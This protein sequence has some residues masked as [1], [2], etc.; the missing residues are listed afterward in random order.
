M[1]I[2][3]AALY[4]I[5]RYGFPYSLDNYLKAVAEMGSAGFEYCELEINVDNDL[6]EYFDRESEVQRALTDHKMTISSIIGV[7][8]GAFS[9]NTYIAQDYLEKFRR[10]CRFGADVGCENIC[11][12]AYMPPEIEGI[13]GS[14]VYAGS[15]P[16]RVRIPNGFN[17]DIFWENAVKQFA[18][19]ARI[20]AEFDQ[21]LIIENRVGDFINT[22]DGVLKLIED[23]GEPNAGCLLD[24]AHCN[25]TREHID[26]VIPKLKKR[27]LYVHLADNDGT[28][29]YHLPAGRGK[30][31][32]LGIFRSLSAIGY[33]SFVNVDY[34]GV[35]AEQILAEVTKGRLYFQECLDTVINE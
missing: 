17:W 15:P 1:K 13:K 14:E 20:C 11:I 28:Y 4:P 34:G 10:L 24:V 31:D 7:V 9:T 12:C 3:C 2:G 26:L 23:A 21:K 33:D 8:S 5:T 18:S 22:S 6:Q 29:S 16:L 35:P 25:A 30:I 19:M 27:L 32:F